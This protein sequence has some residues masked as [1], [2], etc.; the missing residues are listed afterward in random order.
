MMKFKN[1]ISIRLIIFLV[2]VNT[3]SGILKA[4]DVIQ[5]SH[6]QIVVSTEDPLSFAAA[7]YLSEQI[8]L[9]T[10]LNLSVQNAA[11][12]NGVPRIYL[13]LAAAFET[14][15]S[16]VVPAKQ[17]SY[18]IWIDQNAGSA[19]SVMLAGRDHRGLLFATGRLIRELYLSDGYISL[20]TRLSIASAPADELRAHQVITNSQ[21]EDGFMDWGNAED[22]RK[23]VDELILVGANGFEPTE[24]QLLDN[25]LQ[26]LGIDLFV[27]LKCQEII[28]LDSLDDDAVTAFFDNI[29]VSTTLPPMAGM[30][31]D[32]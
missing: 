25:Y 12:D 28:D 18:A 9:R 27:K 17:E 6:A 3:A 10:G 8:F 26:E 20:D 11:T 13:G 30:P 7:E 19:V 15:G 16:M 22:L 1:A 21:S 14:P 32:Q 23:H 29:P 4:G 2:I 24:P 5:L 31:A